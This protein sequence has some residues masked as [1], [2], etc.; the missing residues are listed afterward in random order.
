MSS[1][2][3]GVDR[4]WWPRTY[5]SGLCGN[6]A[7]R[8]KRGHGAHRQTDGAKLS[9]LTS[10][11]DFSID[12]R[13][14]ETICVDCPRIHPDNRA[15]RPPLEADASQHERPGVFRANQAAEFNKVRHF[16]ILSISALN[17]SQW[18]S[19]LQRVQGEPDNRTRGAV[20]GGENG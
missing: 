7:R 15:L 16:Q 5:V 3:Q 12:H 9:A 4:P 10:T 6:A 19:E 18:W 14:I 11:D 13:S 8:T 2:V 1:G 20:S 17:L